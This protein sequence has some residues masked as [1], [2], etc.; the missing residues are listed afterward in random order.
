MSVV[1][2]CGGKAQVACGQVHTLGV[3]KE[4][5][6][7]A[8]GYG[9]N[10]A[11]GNGDT[12]DQLKPTEVEAFR[13]GR[14]TKDSR[15]MY[16]VKIKEVAAFNVS[17]AVGEDKCLY[18]WGD[19]EWISHPNPT[20]RA[21]MIPLRLSWVKDEVT[22][23]KCG[24]QHA[25]YLAA[26]GAVMGWG[27]PHGGRLG[28]EGQD[29]RPIQGWA[30]VYSYL[31][32][33]GEQGASLACGEH[34]SVVMC[35]Q[36]PYFAN[37]ELLDKALTSL[38][39]WYIAWA[40]CGIITNASSGAHLS[41]QGWMELGRVAH[42]TDNL[43]LPHIWDTWFD[44]CMQAQ[45]PLAPT[46]EYNPHLSKHM[47]MG[48]RALQTITF[49]YFRCGLVRIAEELYP[50]EDLSCTTPT[51]RAH[52]VGTPG[53]RKANKKDKED[54]MEDYS[55]LVEVPKIVHPALAVLGA[56]YTE[57]QVFAL[58]HLLQ[59]N[60]SSL[61][62]RAQQ[63]PAAPT[64][65]R[66]VSSW[67]VLGH[68]QGESYLLLMQLYAYLSFG[69][70]K[71]KVLTMPFKML[72]QNLQREPDTIV[73]LEAFA[74]WA[75]EEGLLAADMNK[76]SATPHIA[77]VFPVA[78]LRTPDSGY[79]FPE[80][81]DAITS[82][83][84]FPHSVHFM[85]ASRESNY[86]TAA[87]A[88]T[89]SSVTQEEKLDSVVAKVRRWH[90]KVMNPE[91]FRT[92]ERSLEELEEECARVYASICSLGQVTHRITINRMGFCKVVRDCQLADNKILLT[93]LDKLFTQIVLG[94]GRRASL[95]QS[96]DPA[97]DKALNF[98][99]DGQQGQQGARARSGSNAMLQGMD[100]NMFRHAME[101]IANLKYGRELSSGQAF[102]KLVEEHFVKYTRER[103]TTMDEFMEELVDQDVTQL[104][105]KYQSQL[106]RMFN[107]Y[108][109]LD[110]SVTYASN[111]TSW[112]DVKR[113]DSTMS[114]LEL[115]RLCQDK[116][117]I[118]HHMS[119]TQ[120]E[121]T[122][123][124][125]NVGVGADDNFHDL[126]F[127]EY[128]DALG[129]I[130]LVAYSKPKYSKVLF[131]PAQK[132]TSAR[133]TPHPGLVLHHVSTL[134]RGADAAALHRQIAASDAALNPVNILC[135]Q[136]P[137]P[138]LGLSEDSFTSG[139]TFS[140]GASSLWCGSRLHI[141]DGCDH[142]PSRQPPK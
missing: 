125:A 58:K 134:K 39:E 133:S 21:Q 102:R 70:Q 31:N 50:V 64:L 105:G 59:R 124:R 4:G 29:T 11:L 47:D 52:S 2:A 138:Q 53:S 91:M 110:K 24:A 73:T 69:K 23:V 49:E 71:R 14:A 32:L 60:I 13:D 123:R 114:F 82:G 97:A 139:R 37:N 65:L 137:Q 56:S 61:R 80:M 35:K 42:L 90:G 36:V 128:L 6:C 108:C 62:D 27:N 98:H 106:Q 96:S 135:L 30:G 3:T 12:Q 5:L 104:L 40:G 140:L 84:V 101:H 141:L 121:E 76:E 1:R 68:L 79:S 41:R 55:N 85:M 9:G 45:E 17:M 131:H 43:M 100:Y 63:H 33:K 72:F 119:R 95:V 87:G 25:L 78:W 67:T 66:D 75:V 15:K 28:T 112:K 46:K 136:L 120:V 7:Y 22:Q 142:L 107:A 122:F 20:E 51:R 38:Y 74:E 115:L 18:V 126:N 92:R 93:D 127:S 94:H 103:M 19:S 34:H 132:V 26:S 88:P 8:W 57:K 111:D 54:D 117:I 113:A 86:S 44:W 48:D 129:L 109:D 77:S 116:H 118:P 99:T 16:R 89:G 81:V 10:G 83:G 130:A